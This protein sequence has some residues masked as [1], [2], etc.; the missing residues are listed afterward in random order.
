MT[1]LPQLGSVPTW[2]YKSRLLATWIWAMPR[3][4]TTVNWPVIVVL[5]RALSA[6][7]CHGALY[8]YRPLLLLKPSCLNCVQ[9][10]CTAL[11]L[12][13]STASLRF[14]IT[15]FST[16]AKWK[17]TRLVKGSR[18][19]TLVIS[20][21]NVGIFCLY[22]IFIVGNHE[23][24][25]IKSIYHFCGIDLQRHK[26]CFGRSSN[27]SESPCT[28]WQPWTDG[29]QKCQLRMLQEVDQSFAATGL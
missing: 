6:H 2:T 14:F 28:S 21:K 17:I 7:T 1:T 23:N 16:K 5:G 25:S 29:L 18:T 27:T 24:I 12:P 11:P 15:R 19:S 26:P 4:L 20:Y 22:L 9:G 10:I 3:V 13:A 8:R